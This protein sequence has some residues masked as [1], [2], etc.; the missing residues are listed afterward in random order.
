MN[1]FYHIFHHHDILFLSPMQKKHKTS[2]TCPS[3]HQLSLI[4][5][6]YP[7]NFRHQITILVLK[8][9]VTWAHDLRTL[10]INQQRF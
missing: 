6:D 10:V 1:I 8:L 9:M 4:I 3:N 7:T 5:I 2:K